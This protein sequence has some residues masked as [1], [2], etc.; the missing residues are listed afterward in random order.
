MKIN[1]KIFLILISMF[2]ISSCDLL[3]IEPGFYRERRKKHE[4]FRCDFNGEEWTYSYQKSGGW[5][6][7]GWDSPNLRSTFF[8]NYENGDYLE[9]YAN[10]ENDSGTRAQT[11]NIIYENKLVLGKNFLKDTVEYIVEVTDKGTEK[12]LYY[13]YYLDLDFDNYLDITKIDEENGVIEGAFQFRAITKDGKKIIK[14]L[15]GEFDLKIDYWRPIPKHHEFECLLND[16]EWKINQYFY[17][18][19]P[20]RA[21]YI[22][23][24]R[25][26]VLQANNYDEGVFQFYLDSVAGKGAINI[27]QENKPVYISS[28]R[29]NYFIDSSYNNVM[30]ILEIDTIEK[31]A[32]GTFSFRAIGQYW[33]DTITVSNGYFDSKCVFYK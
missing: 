13:K 12:H 19:D 26:F 16:K 21:I 1:S 2:T 5:L 30:E 6:D 10:R 20:L 15:D 29:H 17:G 32:I 22:L 27:N 18:S 33:D 11:I 4:F 31:F 9:L 14:V 7:W 28:R 8:R 23:N 25:E 24:S 3:N